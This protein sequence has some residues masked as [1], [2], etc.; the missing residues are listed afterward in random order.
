MKSRNAVRPRVLL[1]DDHP[2]V[3]KKVEALL[4]PACEIVGK[5]RDGEALLEAEAELHPDIMII[6][7]SMPVLN[8]IDAARQL[9]LSGSKAKIIILT[10]HED[11][12]F[13]RAALSAGVS[14]YV[15]K[16]RMA[17]DLISAVR[18]VLKGHR[19]I[20]PSLASDDMCAPK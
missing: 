4:A 2:A 11:P 15:I 5:L 1:G 3:L 9:K 13:V 17:T 19:F 12:D 8:G 16:S 14:G 10:V 18:E 6:D 20:S 7:I